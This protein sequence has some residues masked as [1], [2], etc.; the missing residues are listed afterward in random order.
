M[1]VIGLEKLNLMHVRLWPR[2]N[3]DL[4]YTYWFHC[5]DYNE[6]NKNLAWD[7]SVE[8]KMT[9]EPLFS[10]IVFFNELADNLR[11]VHIIQGPISVFN[12]AAFFNTCSCVDNDLRKRFGDFEYYH[13]RDVGISRKVVTDIRFWY[14]LH[15]IMPHPRILWHKIIIIF[16]FFNMICGEVFFPEISNEFVYFVSHRSFNERRTFIR[17]VENLKCELIKWCWVICIDA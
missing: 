3:P 16:N 17:R 13:F 9:W 12:S 4:G 8:K 2:K 11:N 14:G 1:I 15:Q 7:N 10:V 5:S 6:S